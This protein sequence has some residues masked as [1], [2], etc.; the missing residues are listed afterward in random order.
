MSHN[1]LFAA[2]TQIRESGLP[3]SVGDDFEIPVRRNP[4][5]VESGV[6]LNFDLRYPCR[7]LEASSRHLRA[8]VFSRPCYGPS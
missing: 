4:Q 8:F 7:G 2:L 6:V 5:S 1:L 3:H